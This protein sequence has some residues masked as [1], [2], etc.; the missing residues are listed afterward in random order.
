MLNF[1]QLYEH[2]LVLEVKASKANI[3]QFR[4]KYELGEYSSKPGE[5]S[6][7]AAHPQNAINLDAMIADLI[8]DFNREV[9]RGTMKQKDIFAF[10]SYDDFNRE[11]DR[12]QSQQTKAELKKAEREGGTR[13]YE[14]EDLLIVHP[15]T[16]AASCA[17]GSGAKWCTASKDDPR[18]FKD[19][20]EDKG[21]LLLYFLPKG[22][23]SFA[24][25]L[26][27]IPKVEITDANIDRAIMLYPTAWRRD[28][29]STARA[30]GGM[31]DDAYGNEMKLNDKNEIIDVDGV[32]F[33]SLAE[34]A[35]RLPN[36]TRAARNRMK[37]YMEQWNAN[38]DKLVDHVLGYGENVDNPD[39]QMTFAA[40]R[41]G[42]MT[43]LTLQWMNNMTLNNN[44][45]GEGLEGI[46]ITQLG[47]P[48]SSSMGPNKYQAVTHMMIDALEPTPPLG[49]KPDGGRKYDKLAV[50]VY[51]GTKGRAG[52]AG[53]N[54]S[55]G[56][57][58]AEAFDAEDN[59]IDISKV[60][61]MANISDKDVDKISEYINKFTDEKI[62]NDVDTKGDKGLDSLIEYMEIESNQTPENFKRADE[63]FI[64]NPLGPKTWNYARTSRG[65]WNELEDQMLDRLDEIVSKRELIKELEGLDFNE[66]LKRGVPDVGKIKQEYMDRD[67]QIMSYF[68]RSAV[69][70]QGLYGYYQ[71]IKGLK[72]PEFEKRILDP[73][74]AAAGL[75]RMIPDWVKNVKK[76]RSP[77][78]EEVLKDLFIQANESEGAT[79]RPPGEK[80]DATERYWDERGRRADLW[81]TGPVDEIVQVVRYLA[82]T[83]A[84]Q[85]GENMQRGSSRQ[86]PVDVLYKDYPEFRDAWWYDPKIVGKYWNDALVEDGNKFKTVHDKIPGRPFFSKD[87]LLP[88]GKTRSNMPSPFGEPLYPQATKDLKDT[89]P[90]SMDPK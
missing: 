59:E 19:Y 54:R 20:T 81:Y 60:M 38:G 72:W 68:L 40:A 66:L 25:Q 77:K 2:I 12:A 86:Q 75:Y 22:K 30:V 42:F 87:D 52:E 70:Q 41:A 29:M 79:L 13:V 35:K 5:R 6:I 47:Q 33:D 82:T 64:K 4:K 65:E 17:F 80:R 49:M 51:T 27:E 1:E 48:G 7:H 67:E 34:I 90:P 37:G 23:P 57:Y 11:L 73:K 8:E 15:Q 71:D 50:A 58:V 9:K 16:H 3:A 89:P 63:I 24:P 62:W 56:P 55:F 78:A 83:Y 53:A 26:P 10:D 46:N 45:R 43:F 84:N 32:V 28:G 39:N 76:E 21:V 36:E 88:V 31:L 44:R 18:Y 74:Y 69:S 14:D 85:M 61:Q